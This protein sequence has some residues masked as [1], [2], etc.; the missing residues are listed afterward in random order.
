MAYPMAMSTGA[1][2]KAPSRASSAGKFASVCVAVTAL[3]VATSPVHAS[4]RPMSHAITSA[5]AQPLLQRLRDLNAPNG[6]AM[7]ATQAAGLPVS[8]PIQA[9]ASTAG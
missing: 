9:S 4:D 5:P 2:T 3:I 8:H 7:R 6:N 1:K